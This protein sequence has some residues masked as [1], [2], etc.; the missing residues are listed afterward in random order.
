MEKEKILV[1]NADQY[2]LES[3]TNLNEK[4]QIFTAASIE[5]ALQ[6]YRDES[7]HTVITEINENYPG[8]VEVVRKLQQVKA[9]TPILVIT[10]H[11]S[12][13]V[14]IEAMKAGA[15]DYITKPFNFDEL[16]LVVMHSL[17]RK[18]LEE[19]VRE[20]RLLQD[21]MFMDPLTQVYNRRF[22]DELL[23]HEEWRAKRYPQKFSL[24]IIDIDGFGDFNARYGA[25]GGDK[26]LS[27]LGTML[28]SR[29]RNTD[30]VARFDGEKFAVIT[31]HT[32]K[33]NA[34]ILASRLLVAVS[35]EQFAIGGATAG[36][37]VSIGLS[38][39]NEDAFT[40][41]ALILAAEE[42]LSQAKRLGKNRACLFGGS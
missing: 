10:S 11:N 42:A 37:T 13:P 33:K 36:V 38:T 15:Y 22:F 4:Y 27:C 25:E 9:D 26:V 6:K 39:F 12:I 14:A 24:L 16:R 7:F 1:I 17:E 19:E 28:K 20:T 18:K 29:V 2:V 23:Q 21:S 40:R 32:E 5:D 3:L 34:M 31:P 41:E 30:S 35:M 8:G